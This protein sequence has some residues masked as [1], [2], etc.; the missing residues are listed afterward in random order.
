MKVLVKRLNRNF[1]IEI[2]EEDLE[3]GDGVTLNYYSDR[4]PATIIEIGPKGKYLKVQEDNAKRIDDN[5]MSDC[6]SY[7]ITRNEKGRVY[8]FYK[9]R[10]KG[11]TFY[12][13]TG[14]STYNQY[15]IYLTLK[16]RDKY[17]DYSF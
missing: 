12:T 16:H 6:Q 7:E 13:N 5:G 8:Y 3:V 17:Y 1:D 2:V 10:K 9:T 4:V 14:R 15:G 11:I